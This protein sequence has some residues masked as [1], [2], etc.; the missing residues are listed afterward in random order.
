MLM[1]SQEA[2]GGDEERR[3]IGRKPLDRVDNQKREPN[4]RLGMTR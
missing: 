4:R 3:I 2:K 1:T